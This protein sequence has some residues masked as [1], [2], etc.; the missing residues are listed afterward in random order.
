MTCAELQDQLWDLSDP[1]EQVR[2]HLER[3]RPCTAAR[4]EIA[5][6][7]ETLRSPSTPLLPEGVIARMSR[8]SRKGIVLLRIAAALMIGFLT[9]VAILRDP[10]AS[11]VRRNP[12]AD[13]MARLLAQWNDDPEFEQTFLLVLNETLRRRSLT[14]IGPA[15][16]SMEV[17][18]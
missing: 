8:P 11:P 12:P 4:T 15:A 17:R 10:P 16:I 2:S 5:R 7:R 1:P 9:A 6:I 3:C 13:P 14:A 18:Q